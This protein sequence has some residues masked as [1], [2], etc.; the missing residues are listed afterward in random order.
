MIKP[1][2]AYST[3]FLQALAGTTSLYSEPPPYSVYVPRSTVA[4]NFAQIGFSIS[5]ATLSW[6]SYDGGKT[7]EQ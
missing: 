6:E 7:P 3:A 2:N 4:Q 5:N 1:R